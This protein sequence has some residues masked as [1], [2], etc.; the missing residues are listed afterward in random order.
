M[1]LYVLGE[2]IVD[3]PS[4]GC[5]QQDHLKH[6]KYVAIHPS[7]L[8]KLVS[9]SELLLAEPSTNWP[10]SCITH[11]PALCD[12]DAP[13]KC[14]NSACI[15]YLGNLVNIEALNDVSGMDIS[16]QTIT[17]YFSNA[18]GDLPS[19]VSTAFN[20]TDSSVTVQNLHI[21][22]WNPTDPL[23]SVFKMDNNSSLTISGGSFH[24]CGKSRS[25]S[26]PITF[27]SLVNSSPNFSVF[28]TAS[29]GP[30][31]GPAP[32]PSP[33]PIPQI[34]VN[35]C[36][37]NDNHNC[38]F[39]NIQNPVP[40]PV[41][42]T[43]NNAHFTDN[44]TINQTGGIISISA[45][46]AQTITMTGGTTFTNN[47][48]TGLDGAGGAIYSN[49]DLKI[50]G[51]AEF[52]GNEAKGGG[53][54]YSNGAIT[55]DGS[56]YVHGNKAVGSGGALYSNTSVTLQ[57]GPFNFESNSS[58]GKGNGGAI[59]SVSG[60]T[61][62]GT[63]PYNFTDNKADFSGTCGGC[64]CGG[65]IYSST[66][67]D[68]SST[69]PVTFTTNIAKSNGGAIYSKGTVN[70]SSDVS[71]SK[72][73]TVDQA[74]KTGGAIYTEGSLNL[75]G[76]SYFE[77]GHA[78]SW[79]DAYKVVG[80]PTNDAV[81][82][83][84]QEKAIWT[85]LNQPIFSDPSGNN[86][87]IEFEP[88]S[89]SVRRPIID[90]S[91]GHSA[92][93]RTTW[94]CGGTANQKETWGKCNI[95]YTNQHAFDTS[96]GCENGGHCDAFYKCNAVKFAELNDNGQFQCP[97]EY[98]VA[99][100]KDMTPSKCALLGAMLRPNK[101][102]DAP[103]GASLLTSP[104]VS[105]GCHMYLN[106][107]GE[108]DMDNY[109]IIYNNRT[110]G[111]TINNKYVP[112]CFL[113]N[114]SA[115]CEAKSAYEWDPLVQ[116][117]GCNS[118]TCKTNDTKDTYNC[119]GCNHPTP[120]PTP[121]PTPVP[122]YKCNG[123]ALATLGT[124]NVYTCPKDMNIG[125]DSNTCERYGEMLWPN[126]LPTK[127]GGKSTVTATDMVHGCHMRASAPYNVVYNSTQGHPGTNHAFVPI[128]VNSSGPWTC[129]AA[130]EKNGGVFTSSNL[131]KT[132]NIKCKAQN[133]ETYPCGGCKIPPPPAPPPAPHPTPAPPVPAG[134]PCR[135]LKDAPNVPC[136]TGYACTYCIWPGVRHECNSSAGSCKCYTIGAKC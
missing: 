34:K 103:L 43:L 132:K 11:K 52:S 135:I 126:N 107:D 86:V 105:L 96:Y 19:T 76:N 8:K 97:L 29:G 16:G 42:L 117:A 6:Q 109:S 17:L 39:A 100:A 55:L 22:G 64:A 26:E 53:A 48:I 89:N 24:D 122:M 120:A 121:V 4:L 66:T 115:K 118:K 58:T 70:L 81:H 50:T 33:A 80:W 68:I 46:N 49:T 35:D 63:G 98:V 32:G 136:A 45:D 104:D 77:G 41:P 5:I 101:L 25:N 30:A 95:S 87:Q 129:E 127:P 92:Y 99:D 85:T 13:V 15:S 9:A 113:K 56:F 37:F 1:T 18:T 3:G 123:V 27:I 90:F 112:I 21:S 57:N 36:S 119:G 62:I 93:P 134:D 61:L 110:A 102:A 31:P 94:T 88:G 71:F 7:G 133:N 131:C 67:V 40:L 38:Q 108:E 20:I 54:I 23:A 74:E 116:P 10:D 72:N 14:N 79:V 83:Y 44:S 2:Y 111:A 125:V 28:Q 78:S 106:L 75:N 91:S 128:C 51:T 60:V 73:Q 59:Y 84:A 82:I 114:Q 130:S 69:K 12:Q 124:N 47:I 65:A